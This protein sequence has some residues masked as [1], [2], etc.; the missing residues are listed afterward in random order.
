MSFSKVSRQRAGNSSAPFVSA[1]MGCFFNA[2]AEMAHCPSLL[3]C[4]QGSSPV[5]FAGQHC[6]E[7]TAELT[8]NLKKVP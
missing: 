3:E 7:K 1:Q 4:Q 8:R 5:F 2:S 6:P